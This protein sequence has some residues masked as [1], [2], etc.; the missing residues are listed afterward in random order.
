M[1]AAWPAG[2]P[3]EFGYSGKWCR[4]VSRGLVGDLPQ[5]A[6]RGFVG[7]VLE[8]SEVRAR[9]AS[10][11]VPLDDVASHVAAK[12]THLL[13][14]DADERKLALEQKKLLS[15]GEPSQS[16]KKAA[17][18]PVAP[19]KQSASEKKAA[20]KPAASKPAASK[21]PAAAPK[22][23]AARRS[24]K[25]RLVELG[26]DELHSVLQFAGPLGLGGAALACKRLLALVKSLS[27]EAKGAFDRWALA[28]ACA[29][30]AWNSLDR[31]MPMSGDEASFIALCEKTGR[32][33]RCNE[34]VM[35]RKL[36]GKAHRGHPG[37][38]VIGAWGRAYHC[39]ATD[40][41]AEGGHYLI[42]TIFG[43]IEGELVRGVIV[44]HAYLSDLYVA[45]NKPVGRIQQ[46]ALLKGSDSFERMRDSL[47]CS[48]RTLE[49]RARFQNEIV[50]VTRPSRMSAYNGL[51]GIDY[52]AN[53]WGIDY[54]AGLCPFLL[55]SMA[56]PNLPCLAEL[57]T[58]TLKCFRLIATNNG[59]GAPTFAAMGPTIWPSRD[60]VRLICKA[61]DARLE[62]FKQLP[63]NINRVSCVQI[64]PRPL[65]WLS[66]SDLDH[67]KSHALWGSGDAAG[68]EQLW[69]QLAE[70]D[71]LDKAEVLLLQVVRLK[72]QHLALGAA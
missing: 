25:L 31:C 58:L 7:E 32:L 6:A 52:A 60:V 68:L 62:E 72:A 54:V 21:K 65:R 13:W 55:A 35:L 50:R 61:A 71:E 39:K 42:P 23:Q 10:T 30:M 22:Q 20:S 45:S 69:D 63:L 28:A 64:K 8:L 70:A 11:P 38:D 17:K 26:D 16:K 40:P 36:P 29:G 33:R 14:T 9:G 1:A 66:A 59:F 5:A 4:A 43:C 18:Q 15:Q 3:C 48:G 67:L 47:D 53:L 2:T 49:G 57:Q 34:A 56:D 44:V 51:W 37:D 46:V 19:Q 12:G 27:A 24:K 41:G